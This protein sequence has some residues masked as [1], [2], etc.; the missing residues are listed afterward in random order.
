MSMALAVVAIEIAD[1]LVWIV[2]EVHGAFVAGGM[3]QMT[4]RR[5]TFVK[6][7]PAQSERNSSAIITE[8]Q[9]E[10]LRLWIK[11][12]FFNLKQQGC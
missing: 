3:R 12:A 4:E 10:M 5:A 7:S 11:A 1:I 9:A 6:N 8:P 2:R